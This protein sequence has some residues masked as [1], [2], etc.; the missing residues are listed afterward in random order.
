MDPFGGP[1]SGG[2]WPSHPPGAHPPQY[3]ADPFAVDPF[4]SSGPAGPYAP[5]PQPQ[6]HHEE[7]NTLA[8]LSVV[9]SFVFAPVGAVLGHLALSQ[10]KQR[11]QRGRD[12]ALVGITLSYS[13]IVVLVVGLVVWVTLPTAKQTPRDTAQGST[14]TTYPPT[15][16]SVTTSASTTP[17]T[18]PSAPPPPVTG[19]TI[20]GVLLDGEE[21]GTI[22]GEPFESAPAQPA[23]VGGLDQ[24]PN[25]LATEA[26]A[27]P[28]DCVAATTVAQRSTYQSANV[29][30][31]A[32]EE[33]RADGGD[34]VIEA[35][36]AV[37]AL[38]TAADAQALFSTL[39]EQWRRCEGQTVT[40]LAGPAPD[41]SNFV[42]KVTN[43]RVVDSVVAA[44]IQSDHTTG[45]WARPEARA[46]GV[47][48]NTLVEVD[49]SF[50]G[51]DLST[52]PAKPDTAGIDVV[53]ALVAKLG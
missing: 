19:N 41:G 32:G 39:S 42:D 50:H 37:V 49:V 13:I 30:A 1:P 17:P 7:T 29:T 15:S 46:I 9:F 11:H 52:A 44:T 47:R 18:S 6:Q 28:H 38:P 2:G 53:R 14:A 33:W 27:S 25:G 16:S 48:G 8:T 26:Q 10:I 24:M 5:P 20:A 35:D 45:G 23:K 31:Y 40:V 43:V 4:G 3:S 12:R 51:G 34:A 22:L 36:E 21:L